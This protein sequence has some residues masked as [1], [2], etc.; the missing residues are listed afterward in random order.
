M[1][2]LK[3]DFLILLDVKQSMAKMC[4]LYKLQVDFICTT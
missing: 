2:S 4:L 3:N 1:I